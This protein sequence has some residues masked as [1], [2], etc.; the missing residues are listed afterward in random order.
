MQKKLSKFDKCE[1]L[2]DTRHD[3][4]RESG[5]TT[6][7]WFANHGPTGPKDQRGTSVTRL[8]CLYQIC[9]GPNSFNSVTPQLPN[10]LTPQPNSGN[11]QFLLGFRVLRFATHTK[12]FTKISDFRSWVAELRSY[13]VEEL[14]S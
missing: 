8:V 6:I 4:V 10:S 3:R 13:G 5:T 7:Q 9:G 12:T 14:R 1:F 11:P 2:L